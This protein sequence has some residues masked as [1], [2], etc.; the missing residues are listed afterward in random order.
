MKQLKNLIILML[1][2]LG[3]KCFALNLDSQN[4]KDYFMSEKY[5]VNFKIAAAYEPFKF[6][7]TD[8]TYFSLG[9][10]DPTDPTDP[11][12]SFNYNYGRTFERTNFNSVKHRENGVSID[13]SA[14]RLYL[15]EMNE[16]NDDIK[17]LKSYCG[18]VIESPFELSNLDSIQK[19]AKAGLHSYCDRFSN[20]E[21]FCTCV[22]DLSEH[23]KLPKYEAEE[24]AKFI[25]EEDLKQDLINITNEF[26]KHAKL[27]YWQLYSAV[28]TG[29]SVSHENFIK[30]NQCS[31]AANMIVSSLKDTCGEKTLEKLEDMHIV[32][33]K[34]CNSEVFCKRNYYAAEKIG[35][36]SG[37]GVHLDRLTTSQHVLGNSEQG[38]NPENG[39]KLLRFDD[40][41]QI[42]NSKSI[43]VLGS[44][45]LKYFKEVQAKGISAAGKSV[46]GNN[47]A[48]KK[49]AFKEIMKSVPY[50]DQERIFFGD[51]DPSY[52]S[53]LNNYTNQI[54][55]YFEKFNPNKKWADVTQKEFNETLTDFMNDELINKVG[56]SCEKLKEQFTKVCKKA[57]NSVANNINIDIDNEENFLLLRNKYMKT[58]PLIRDQQGMK[59]NFDQFLCARKTNEAFNYTDGGIA[60]IV[61]MTT[62]KE[63]NKKDY[64]EQ[65]G[66]YYLR[67]DSVFL[68]S[69]SQDQMKFEELSEMILA[70]QEN[71]EIE[72]LE[73]SCPH[74]SSSSYAYSANGKRERL[75]FSGTCLEQKDFDKSYG[76]PPRTLSQ[77]NNPRSR[78]ILS[79]RDQAETRNAL[80]ALAKEHI[81]QQSSSISS[82]E[83][84]K[85]TKSSAEE[86]GFFTS[87]KKKIFDDKD[88][89]KHSSAKPIA[90]I[91]QES[92]QVEKSVFDDFTS[93]LSNDSLEASSAISN[94]GST[95]QSSLESKSYQLNRNSKLDKRKKDLENKVSGLESRLTNLDKKSTSDKK[96]KITAINTDAQNDAGL[97]SSMDL[98]LQKQ[99]AELKSELKS[100]KDEMAKLEHDRRNNAQA[101]MPGPEREINQ[102]NNS[103]RPEVLPTQASSR[104]SQTENSHTS[105]NPSAN[106]NY[107][108]PANNSGPM[109]SY[110]EK[111]DGSV[112]NSAIGNTQ[113]E[114]N[115]SIVLNNKLQGPTNNFYQGSTPLTKLTQSNLEQLYEQYSN[116]VI[117]TRSENGEV[118]YQKIEKDDVSGLLKLVTLD[119]ENAKKEKRK[120]IA[121]VKSAIPGK[122]PKS[123]A[124]AATSR[125]RFHIDQFNSIIDNGMSK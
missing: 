91:K 31:S 62:P 22:S 2:F 35:G 112:S 58:R 95:S 78:G 92:S 109:A 48:F 102:L 107:N 59:F 76:A 75:L 56:K 18:G 103:F 27:N 50:I 101:V 114:R 33:D 32:N 72:N 89:V 93:A 60:D 16:L 36:I 106:S 97:N 45:F 83:S 7:M 41:I 118:T 39:P 23:Q 64:N 122:K 25:K 15:A 69:L 99:I 6:D 85:N 61:T 28:G 73:I 14:D 77:I 81:S 67:S 19:I 5:E 54:M 87:L 82:S 1:I 3:H 98:N 21:A 9:A 79:S 111:R 55:S 90:K 66:R 123:R 104:M 17:D 44:H 108:P 96:D 4:N 86:E 52:K 30:N 40:K 84:I 68:K 24:M 71:R 20:P 125:M 42:V 74:D 38:P 115:S 34:H 121:E 105:A 49:E 119:E 117:M 29:K 26:A 11:T 80:S 57:N 12:N 10:F 70:E 110:T 100:T 53:M 47:L 113:K 116:E 94:L 43:E 124:P 13:Y 46:D 88:D 51:K 37:F 8:V 65:D 63:R 120:N